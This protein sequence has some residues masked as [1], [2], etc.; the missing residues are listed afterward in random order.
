MSAIKVATRYASALLDESVQQNVTEEVYQDLKL[1]EQT[2]EENRELLLMFRSPI[3]NSG[4]KKAAVRSIYDGKIQK[5]T[6]NFLSLLISKRRESSLPDIILA[7]FIEYNVLK[8]IK[9]VDLISAV[10]LSGELEALITKT[11]QKQFSGATLQIRTS[12]NED[13]LGGIVVKVDDKVF[14]SSLQNKLKA[15]KREILAH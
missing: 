8:R 1:I 4:I 11:L 12:V 6:S 15:L 10:P 5:L 3:V 7:Y 9:E 2:L 13:L 14:D